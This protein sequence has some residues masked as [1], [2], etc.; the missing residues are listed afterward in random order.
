MRAKRAS[1]DLF[2]KK[3]ISISEARRAELRLFRVSYKF[4]NVRP[5][6]KPNSELCEHRVRSP[7]PNSELPEHPQKTEHRTLFVPTLHSSHVVVMHPLGSYSENSKCVQKVPKLKCLSLRKQK[8]LERRLILLF[9]P[10]CASK[11]V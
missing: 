1:K 5:N 11:I 10:I 3:T 4:G 2:L 8:K 7:K 6:L 9:D